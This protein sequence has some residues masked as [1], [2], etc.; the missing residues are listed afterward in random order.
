MEETK[1][2]SLKKCGDILNRIGNKFSEEQL[3]AIRDYLYEMAQ[4][5]FDVFIHNQKKEAIRIAEANE[6]TAN[7]NINLKNA[8]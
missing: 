3:T 1:K 7:H 8:A 6:K 5:D 2:I 4:I